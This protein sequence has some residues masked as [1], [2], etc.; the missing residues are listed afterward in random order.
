MH[1]TVHIS[2]LLWLNL[3]VQHGMKRTEAAAWDTAVL[4]S[5]RTGFYHCNIIG[6]HH[7][8]ILHAQVRA[9]GSVHSRA[10]HAAVVH[11]FPVFH[12]A[13]CECAIVVPENWICRSLVTSVVKYTPSLGDSRKDSRSEIFPPALANSARREWVRHQVFVYHEDC[14]LRAVALEFEHT[15][16]LHSNIHRVFTYHVGKTCSHISAYQPFETLFLLMSIH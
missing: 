2:K 7:R 5:Y 16:L 3:R 10:L 6:S 9:N 1:R 13:L 15:S 11:M 8:F 14:I 4:P 12:G